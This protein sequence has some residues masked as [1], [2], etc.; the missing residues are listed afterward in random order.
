[1]RTGRSFVVWCGLA[2]LCAST[3]QAQTEVRQKVQVRSTASDALQVF[4]S[5]FIGTT[6]DPSTAVLDVRSSADGLSSGQRI[7]RADGSYL[8]L[9][10]DDGGASAFGTL[11]AGDGATYRAIKINPNG[12]AV[13]IGANGTTT[14][15]YANTTLVGS[16]SVTSSSGGITM[17]DASLTPGTIVMGYADDTNGAAA[18]IGM[19]MKTGSIRYFWIDSDGNMRIHTGA[20]NTSDANDN[21]SYGGTAVGAQTSTRASKT[22][23]EPFTAFDDAL[24]LVLRTPLYAFTYREGDPNTRHVGIMADE[25]PEFV[26]LAGTAFDPINGFGYTAAAIKALELRLRALEEKQR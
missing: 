13:D 22:D 6:T 14:T 23:I 24:A 19:K 21:A 12:G 2:L 15:I 16:V 4:G 17:T 8:I 11:Q 7:S 3:V 10:M 25:S 18:R 20:P 9:N 5:A 1:M 26:R